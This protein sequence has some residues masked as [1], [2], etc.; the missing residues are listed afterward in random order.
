MHQIQK[1]KKLNDQNLQEDECTEKWSKKCA[2]KIRQTL[3]FKKIQKIEKKIK[4]R[5]FFK[6]SRSRRKKIGNAF[7]KLFEN[8]LQFS[9]ED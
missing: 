4:I 7:E 6:N 3:F 2:S 5:K 9:L 8:N 1:I